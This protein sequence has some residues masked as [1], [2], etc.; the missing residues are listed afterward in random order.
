MV[1]YY[2]DGGDAEP[3]DSDQAFP[4]S[5]TSEPKVPC[6]LGAMG[7]CVL[8]YARIMSLQL[9]AWGM[10]RKSATQLRAC[11]YLFGSGSY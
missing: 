8:L 7:D 1:A 10:V 9:S 6:V 5:L 2:I 3:S 4:Y 11:P